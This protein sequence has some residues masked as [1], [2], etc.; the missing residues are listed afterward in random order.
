MH[1]D[2][3]DPVEFVGYLTQLIQQSHRA[4][5]G[6]MFTI[7]LGQDQHNAWTFVA[8]RAVVHDTEQVAR[9]RLQYGKLLLLEEFVSPADTGL[10]RIKQ[11]ILGDGSC[12]GQQFTVEHSYI[13]GR[14]DVPPHGHYTN[15]PEWVF[16]CSFKRSNERRVEISGNPAV[17]IGQPPFVSWAHAINEWLAREPLERHNASSF[18]DSHELLIIIPDTR[19]RI[20]SADWTTN[21]ARVSLDSNCPPEDLELQTLF[22]GSR[23]QRHHV[24]SGPSASVEVE[25]PEDATGIWHCLLHR[26][27]DRLGEISLSQI[28]RRYDEQAEKLPLL[29]QLEQDLKWGER[30]EV[31]F[32]PFIKVG[33]DIKED[34]LMRTV[35]AF[36]NTRGG[37]IYLG[38]TDHREV[39]TSDRFRAAYNDKNGALAPEVVLRR[40]IHKLIEDKIKPVP[41][42]SIHML[43][44][45]GVPIAAVVVEHGDER[46]YSTKVSNYIYIRQGGSDV[47]P[48]PQS[49]L[50]PLFERPAPNW[51][52]L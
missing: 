7:V 44:Y 5:A 30:E 28:D 37:R 47:Q 25:V 50:K 24:V 38:I 3:R 41:K 6:I 12:D 34:D 46:P 18:N 21:R 16:R 42:V 19:A 13:G 4:P 23:L 22:W 33:D 49:E 20:L 45:A 17:A 36:A 1:L 52:I 11:I 29:A 15:W 35:I 39:E 31:E 51:N 40:R 43:E 9:A 26:S 14:R 8:G 32:K 48:D 27:G 2:F 10:Q